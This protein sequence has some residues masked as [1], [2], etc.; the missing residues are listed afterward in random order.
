MRLP[1]LYDAAEKVARDSQRAFLACLGIEL[2][3]LLIAAFLGQ[4]PRDDFGGFGPVGALLAF[5]LALVLRVSGVGGRA[6]RRWY[7]AR[8]AAESCKS[9][10]WQFAVGGEGYRCDSDDSEG[11]FRRDLVRVLEA[12]PRLNVPAGTQT[13]YGVTTEMEELRGRPRPERERVY[14]T[15]RVDDQLAWYS[16]KAEFNRQR[17]KQWWIAA[18]AIESLA[19]VLGL[20]RVI[21][22]FDVDWLGVL[23]TAAAALA[24]WQQTKNFSGLS[25]AYAVTSH[26]VGM[27]KDAMSKVRSEQEW[28]QFVHDAEAAFSREHTLWLARRQGPLV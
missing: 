17:S 22:A 11:R 6:E 15:R 21:G 26:E 9:L 12:L 23:A 19:V 10:A 3:S 5:L 4:L 13:R 1:S 20:A 18:V 28:A 2:A 25:E 8:A 7:D 24:A 16:N 14:E 27:I